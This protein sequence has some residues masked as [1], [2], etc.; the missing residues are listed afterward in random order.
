LVLQLL[1]VGAVGVA[2]ERVI[3][4]VVIGKGKNGWTRWL[5]LLFGLRWQSRRVLQRREREGGA[6]TM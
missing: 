2:E 6:T 4:P 3:A 5:L 1:T